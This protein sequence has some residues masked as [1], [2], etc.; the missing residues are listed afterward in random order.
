MP[1]PVEGTY[2]TYFQNYINQV[3]EDNVFSALKNQEETITTFFDTISEEKSTYAYAEGKWTLKELLLHIIDAERIFNY[4]ALAFARKEIQSLPGFDENSYAA[5]S[6]ANSRTWKS[7]C[8]ELKAVRKAT[9]LLFESFSPETLNSSGFANNNPTTV[10]AMGFIIVGH[11]YHH[12]NI[13]KERY[14]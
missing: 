11:V 12:V 1:K 2:P 10:N 7:L 14:L 3:N 9:Q 8:E 4:R 5:N 13:I 6:Y